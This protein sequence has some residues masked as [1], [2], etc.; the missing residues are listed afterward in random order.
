MT[1]KEV[2]RSKPVCNRVNVAAAAPP[3]INVPPRFRD[4]ATFEKGEN[5]VLKIPFTG[6][7][8]PTVKWTRDAEEIKSGGRYSIEVGDRHA[9]LTIRKGEKADD[10]PYRLTLENDLGTDSAV[11]KIQVNGR[12]KM[13]TLEQ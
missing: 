5:I 10:G 6:F 12:W 9:F 1:D 11:I 13:N 3:K 4:V 7:P 8:K 2:K